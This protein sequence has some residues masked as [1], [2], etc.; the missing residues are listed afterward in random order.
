MVF[1]PAKAAK[2]KK[3][4]ISIVKRKYFILS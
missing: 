2:S 3:P 4:L 1:T